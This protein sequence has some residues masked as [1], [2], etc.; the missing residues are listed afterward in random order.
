MQLNNKKADKL[1]EKWIKD[2]GSPETVAQNTTVCKEQLPRC[3][4]SPAGVKADD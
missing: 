3:S 4:Q 2:L 1:I